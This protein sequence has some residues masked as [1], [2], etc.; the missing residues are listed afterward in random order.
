MVLRKLKAHILRLEKESTA[1]KPPTYC[2]NNSREILH[3]LPLLEVIF[4]IYYSVLMKV[5][6]VCEQKTDFLYFIDLL[7]LTEVP[8]YVGNIRAMSGNKKPK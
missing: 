5:H 8:K 2:K 4:Q 3:D 6:L 1:T 7:N